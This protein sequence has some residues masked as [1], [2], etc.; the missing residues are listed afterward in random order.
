M[1]PTSAQ[2]LAA[3]TLALLEAGARGTYHVTDGG[4]CTW[5]E[6]ARAIGAG[7]GGG[8]EI[9][10]CTTAEFPRPAPR[11]AYS[12]LDLSATEAI[13]GAMTDW[14]VLLDRVLKAR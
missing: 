11:P 12:V 4:E 5:F 8:A 3:S 1:I 2:H 10:P 14:H 9:A 7:V 6:F 13:I